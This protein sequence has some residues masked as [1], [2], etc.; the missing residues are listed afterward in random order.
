MEGTV[1]MHNQ[2]AFILGSDT[3]SM[4]SCIRKDQVL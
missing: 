4:Q 2:V 1:M 3:S